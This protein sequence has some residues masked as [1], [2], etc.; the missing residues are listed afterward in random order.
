M[1]QPSPE[2]HHLKRG[3]R[4]KRVRRDFGDKPH[5]FPRRQA[6]DE[7]VELEHEPDGVAAILGQLVF[8]GR[9][10][11]HVPIRQLTGGWHVQTAEVIQ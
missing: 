10:E 5:V 7:I 3:F 1:V 2:V 9:G 11:V 8:I 6:R 4:R